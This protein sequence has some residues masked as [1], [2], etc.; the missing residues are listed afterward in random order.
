[1]DIEAIIA[2]DKYLRQVLPMPESFY[3]K[4]K[5]EKPK[6]L[7]FKEALHSIQFTYDSGTIYED[8]NLD[9]KQPPETK[10]KLKF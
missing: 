3:E 9:K 8:G 6:P 5:L 4:Y 1:M 2:K 10:D 7:E